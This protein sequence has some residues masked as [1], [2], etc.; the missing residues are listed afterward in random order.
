MSL[1]PYFNGFDRQKLLGLFG[2]GSRTAKDSAFV[3]IGDM[4]RGDDPETLEARR[5]CS[6][7]ITEAID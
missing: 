6:A 2:S 4:L 7:V 5:K 3:L 1:R